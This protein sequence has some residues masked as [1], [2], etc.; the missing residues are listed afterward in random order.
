M[1]TLE[2]VFPMDSS[3]LL[4]RTAVM[5]DAPAFLDYLDNVAGESD[6]LTFG[7]GE[8]VF[9][10][11][12]EEHLIEE[13]AASTNGLFLLAWFQGRIVGSLTF[14]GGKRPKLSH[15]GEFGLSV[16][17]IHW[18]K[19]IGSHL[20]QT[21][22]DW[23]PTAQ[24]G[25]IHLQ[26]RSDN[27]R[28]IALYTRH[29]FEMEGT[30]RDHFFINGIYYDTL[31]MGLRIGKDTPLD[32]PVPFVASDRPTGSQSF[33]VRTANPGDATSILACV[34]QVCRETEFLSMGT[35]GPGLGIAEEE[36]FLATVQASPGSLYLVAVM[37][38]SVVG[39]LS[40][41]ASTRQRVRHFGEFSLGVLGAYAG[42]GIGR[43]LLNRLIAWARVSGIHKINL[44]VR[45][46]NQRAI[47]LYTSCGFAIE[48]LITRTVYYNGGYHDSYAM[49]LI[50]G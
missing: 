31:C 39:Y 24:I 17:R 1:A 46:E 33:V 19:G 26:V 47:D 21:L 32:K 2:R 45:T 29:G 25:K 12:D 44:E 4:V 38:T 7:R 9:A 11:G 16:S 23:A 13:V 35:E 42:M 30:I 22:I 8:R 18:G 41:A 28:A 3:T 36:Q 40:F 5:V 34:G 37:G 6:N 48:A 10:L 15:S 20:L 27:G 50:I 14:Q 49:G 43:A